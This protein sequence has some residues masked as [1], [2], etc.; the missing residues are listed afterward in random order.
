MLQGLQT[1]EIAG[2]NGDTPDICMSE[3][4]D[5]EAGLEEEFNR[6][7]LARLH[8]AADTRGDDHVMDLDLDLDFDATSEQEFDLEEDEIR[9]LF[10][11]TGYDDQATHPEDAGFSKIARAEY[12]EGA[13]R[14][15]GKGTTLHDKFAQD[16]FAYD[17]ERSENVYFPFS[18]RAEWEFT[19]IL[20]RMQCSLAQKTEL[21]NTRLVSVTRF[22][23]CSELIW[24]TAEECPAF[25]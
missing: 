16:Q 21:L 8:V 13:G 5:N 6:L 7:N 20:M 18:S 23:I 15:Y 2:Q 22:G 1:D 9:L 14:I 4:D 12:Y 10:R 11:E 17:R 3:G 24:I 25:V 19:N